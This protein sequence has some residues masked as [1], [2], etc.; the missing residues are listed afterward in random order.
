[1]G[2]HGFWKSARRRLQPRKPEPL[3]SQEDRTL[4]N[5]TEVRAVCYGLTAKGNGEVILTEERHTSLSAGGG[6]AGQ[7]YPCVFVIGVDLYNQSVTG[8][9]NEDLE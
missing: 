6:Q 5:S 3:L 4:P 8:G 1:M 7:G 9:D 2:T